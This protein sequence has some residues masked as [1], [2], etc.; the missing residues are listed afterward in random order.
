MQ[1]TKPSGHV[2]FLSGI[3]E[4]VNRPNIIRRSKTGKPKKK[5]KEKESD[6]MMKFIQ[7]TATAAVFALAAM[8]P[9]AAAG[10]KDTSRN[11]SISFGDGDLLQSLKD[12]DAEDLAE[13][14]AELAEAKA[15]IAE[16]IEEV[17]AARAE[18]KAEFD[19]ENIVQAAFTEAGRAVRT[20]A[21]RAFVEVRAE[22]DRVE[23]DLAAERHEIGEAEFQETQD[24]I[25][26]IRAE[27]A[28]IEGMIGE[29]AAAMEA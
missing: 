17:K 14:K 23:R 8:G 6:P 20:E 28:E 22:L 10:D 13:L 5:T 26:F 1:K 3:A 4:T 11:Y 29:L 18:L 27:L 24:A 15:E 25:E 16:A 21:R 19:D 7:A 9:A 12:L 2:A